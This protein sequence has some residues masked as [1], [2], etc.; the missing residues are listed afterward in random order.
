M[1]KG[2]YIIKA[3]SIMSI[4]PTNRKFCGYSNSQ[5]D[6]KLSVTKNTGHQN[7]LS[8]SSENEDYQDSNNSTSVIKFER[9]PINNMSSLKNFKYVSNEIRFIDRLEPG[10]IT[11]NI[12]DRASSKHSLTN[13]YESDSQNFSQKLNIQENNLGSTFD[14]WKM[15]RNEMMNITSQSI[16]FR[17][18]KYYNGLATTTVNSPVG[19]KF[20]LMSSG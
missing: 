13:I 15:K 6:Q 5:D 9:S 8:E 4:E 19:S 3:P 7:T 18:Q 11:S 14:T 2:E 1:Q 12:K 17:R 20:N 16:S 10:N